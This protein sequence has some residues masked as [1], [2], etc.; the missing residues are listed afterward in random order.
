VAGKVSVVLVS[1]WPCVTDQ[2]FIHLQ[3]HGLSKG[4]KHLFTL[5]TGYDTLPFYVPGPFTGVTGALI[6]CFQEGNWMFGV[7]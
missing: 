5:L 3:N 7:G 6:I 1:N 4:D 2:W